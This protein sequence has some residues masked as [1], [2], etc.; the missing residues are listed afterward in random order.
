MNNT[1]H[2]VVTT[3]LASSFDLKA[4]ETTNP[5]RLS[6]RWIHM[7]HACPNTLW[8]L[9]LPARP[10]VH[11]LASSTL[12]FPMRSYHII[13]KPTFSHIDSHSHRRYSSLSYRFW[14]H[15]ASV[16]AALSPY[17][18]FSLLISL[19]TF[20]PCPRHRLMIGSSFVP[21]PFLFACSTFVSIIDLLKY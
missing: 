13:I 1:K 11:Y 2:Y 17:T 16:L 7:T 9:A 6:R 21:F 3:G 15:N 18:F 10:F 8:L 5:S 14:V 12:L 20:A 19:V 4:K